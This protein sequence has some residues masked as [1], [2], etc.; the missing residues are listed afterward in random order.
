MPYSSVYLTTKEKV[1]NGLIYRRYHLKF[2]SD[3]KAKD[4]LHTHYDKVFTEK[5][6][7]GK[8]VAYVHLST[9]DRLIGGKRYT[10]TMG[11]PDK[12]QASEYCKIFKGSKIIPF[13]KDKNYYTVWRPVTKK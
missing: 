1:K 3:K 6:K 13:G 11:T 2:D 7:N 10:S 12:K 5:Q 4:Y 9:T 8:F